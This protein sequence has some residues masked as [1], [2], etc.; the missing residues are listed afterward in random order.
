MNTLPL[1]AVSDLRRL[2]G[3]NADIARW[4]DEIEDRG[5]L[6]A[7]ALQEVHH[8][9][10]Y[11]LTHTSWAAYIQEV[12][13]RRKSWAYQMLAFAGVSA[14]AD[15]ESQARE[16]VGIDPE[17]Q[18]LIMEEAGQGA[19]ASQVRET[20]ERLGVERLG[21][22]EAKNARQQERDEEKDRAALE[23]RDLLKLVKLAEMG[24]KISRRHGWHGREAAFTAALGQCQEGRRAA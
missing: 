11:L 16:L 20:R 19:T 23:T 12:F 21:R 4:M 22:D 1:P 8:T 10:L 9:K 5:R 2:I 17:M 3:I 18:A 24:V 15:T 13:K 7:L 14:V 6:I